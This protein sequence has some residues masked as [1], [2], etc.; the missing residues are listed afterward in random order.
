[1]KTY[2]TL[3]MQ[4]AILQAHLVSNKMLQWDI[5]NLTKDIEKLENEFKEL[6]SGY[7]QYYD[8]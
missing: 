4:K 3:N 8:F 6:E 5:E 7:D 1:M 2:N